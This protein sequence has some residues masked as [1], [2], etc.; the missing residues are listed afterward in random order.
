M[1]PDLVA[2][3]ACPLD[4]GGLRL[5]GRTLACGSGH[6]FDLARQGYA[7]LTAAPLAHTGDTPEML[8]RRSRVHKAG[9]LAAVHGAVVDALADARPD[10]LPEGIVCDVGTGAGTYLAS[11]LDALPCRTGVGVDVSKAAARRAARCHPRA[12]AVVAD[13][14]RGLPL[15]DASVALLLD[16]FAPRNPAEFARVVTPSGSVVVVTPDPDH[17]AGLRE[18]AGMLDVPAGKAAQVARE[19]APGFRPVETRQVQQQVEVTRELAVDLA[20]MGPSGHHLDPLVLATSFA[21][22]TT[23]REATGR[24]TTG[25]E[26]TGREATGRETTGREA[27]GREATG[28]EAT[29]RTTA[30]GTPTGTAGPAPSTLSVTIAAT[31]SRFQRR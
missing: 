2:A 7:T 31:I 9:L 14:W 26:T 6:R 28:R 25:R 16:V 29:G 5:D 22:P 10:V 21:P 24:E 20:T 1:L 18:R 13:V 19:L 3:L 8:D 4:G 12:G 11:V 23:G 17:L 30:G 15:R 27:T